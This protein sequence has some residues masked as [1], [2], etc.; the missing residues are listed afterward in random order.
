M[1]NT[2][3]IKNQMQDL[4]LTGM[5]NALEASLDEAFREELGPTDLLA[6]LLQAE[7]DWRHERC[8]FLRIRPTLEPYQ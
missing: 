3:H 6:Q 7:A 8:H 1:I 5:L 2:S 4:K